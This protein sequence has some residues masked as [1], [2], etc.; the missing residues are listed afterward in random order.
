M[1]YKVSDACVK[2]GS[3]DREC[4][5]EAISEKDSKR[6]IDPAKCQ[7][8]GVCAGVCPTE[9]I[10]SAEQLSMNVSGK[11]VSLAFFLIALLA[12]CLGAADTVVD[13]GGDTP[14]GGF[15]LIVRLDGRDT[16]FKQYIADVE[17]N[18]RRI[19][20]REKNR[21]QSTAA[22][23]SLTIYQYT[24]AEG[25]DLFS[26]AARCNIP[27]AS[28]ASLNRIRHPAL[29]ETGL[30]L[31]LPS[32]PGVFIPPDPASDLERLLAAARFGGQDGIPVTVS[33]GTGGRFLFYPGDDFT[34]TERAFFLNTG[35]RFPLR[36]FAL[37][38]SYGVRQNPVT[39]NF[40]LHQGLDLAAP[41]GTDVFAVGEG[42]VTEIGE[43]RI[44]GNYVIVRHG[45]SWASLYGHLQKV[46]TSLNSIV[47]SGTLIGKVGS[48]GQSTGP[49]LHFELR[50][51]GRARDPGKYLFQ[52]GGQ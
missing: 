25:D 49:H 8:C 7:D 45:E 1:A 43:D 18:R 33:R 37:T 50:Q 26:L 39:G 22:A 35:F 51:N 4:P 5:V 32:S 48:T 42:T 10:A 38:S 41:E 29:L 36:S 34:S 47:Q 30:P 17:T 15:P 19:F 46:E 3:C 2:C 14:A 24:P 44:Y 21:E 6:W 11:G 12:P 13:T 23:E 27:Y 20:N 28:L 9:A 52:A 31:L 40:R 16:L